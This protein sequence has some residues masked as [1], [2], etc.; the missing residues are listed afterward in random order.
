MTCTRCSKDVE[1]GSSYCRFCGAAVGNAPHGRRLWRVPE[2]GRIGGVCAGIAHYFDVDV[3]LVRIAWVIL[4]ILPG[5]LVGGL[6][7][8]VVAWVLLPAAPSER[9]A[10]AGRR[11]LRSETDR[12]IGGVCGGLA[13]YLGVDT[14]IVRIVSVVLAIYPGA[15]IGGAIAYAILWFII[16]TAQLSI[17]QVSTTA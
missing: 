10:T 13:E 17:R 1:D 4:S 9:R 15:I 5:L 8:Y 3:T 7:A 14:T 2:E 6:L 16:P 12:Q 11:L